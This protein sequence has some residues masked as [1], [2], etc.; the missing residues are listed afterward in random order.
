MTLSHFDAQGQA[1]MVDVSDKAVTDRTAVAVGEVHM[2]PETLAL[3]EAGTA[4]KK[5]DGTGQTNVAVRERKHQRIPRSSISRTLFA[6]SAPSP[7]SHAVPA[8]VMR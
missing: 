7:A 4:K 1:H 2:S 8:S 5:P 6:I 3:V